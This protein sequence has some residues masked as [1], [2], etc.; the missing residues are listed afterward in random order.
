MAYEKKNYSVSGALYADGL[1]GS[2][3]CGNR[4]DG[5]DGADGDGGGS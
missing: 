5:S 4:A 1:C 3:T 2:A